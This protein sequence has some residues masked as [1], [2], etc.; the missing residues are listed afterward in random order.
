M[1]E[2]S[3]K[4]IVSLVIM[5]LQTLLNISG[6]NFKQLDLDVILQDYRYE[7]L[8]ISLKCLEMIFNSLPN[9]FDLIKE[10]M[11]EVLNDKD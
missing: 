9:V 7:E 2:E 11:K 8:N 6:L 1:T 5:R 10:R 4:L 3:E